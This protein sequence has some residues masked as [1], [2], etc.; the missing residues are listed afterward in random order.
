MKNK[1][2]MI[3]QDLINTLQ[4]IDYSHA[5]LIGNS[6]F[7]YFTADIAGKSYILKREFKFK[8][9]K[10]E[11]P[12]ELIKKYQ[13]VDIDKIISMKYG[14]SLAFF[15]TTLINNFKEEDLTLFYNNINELVVKN[16]S[17]KLENFIL[18]TNVNGEYDCKK[19]EISLGNNCIFTTIDHELFH[20]ASSIYNKNI[21]CSGFHYYNKN[22]NVDCGYGL[23]EGYTQTLT[24][25]YF[26]HLDGVQIYFDEVHFA[27]K[28]E[29]IIGQSKMESLYLN[30]NLRGLV[31]ELTKYENEENIMKFIYYLDFINKHI[32]DNTLFIL[33]KKMLGESFKYISRFLLTCYTKKINEEVKNNVYTVKEGI[34]YLM[35]Y[36]CKLGFYMKVGKKSFELLNREDIEEIIENN[37]DFNV[38]VVITIDKK[39]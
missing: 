37:I 38:N 18:S 16:K 15:A 39:K 1:E 9:T 29:E 19:N 26:G 3:I 13:K 20:M 6:I 36:I 5:F 10:V 4:Q 22:L 2:K 30:A 34:D 23:N 33:K 7:I 25:R 12:P 27:K 8:T 24:E 35:K 11:L 31:D 32:Y 28:L 21:K 17:F 14:S